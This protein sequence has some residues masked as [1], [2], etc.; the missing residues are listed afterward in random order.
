MEMES[1]KWYTEIELLP[2]D[3]NLPRDQFGI[4]GFFV[5]ALTNGDLTCV[6]RWHKEFG[7]YWDAEDDFNDR[8]IERDGITHWM[9]IEQPEIE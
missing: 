3:T 2:E 6:T 1:Y 5:V 8:L 7:W 9:R 4:A